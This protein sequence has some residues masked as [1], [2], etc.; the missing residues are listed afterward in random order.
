MNGQ[1]AKA[2]PHFGPVHEPS[3]GL[4]FGRF[5]YLAWLPIPLLAA[6]I[7]VGRAAGLSESYRSE[8]LTLVL[9]FTFY[10]LVSLGTLFLIGRSFLALGTPGLLLL[11]SGVVLW[12]LAGTVGDAVSHGDANVNVTIFNTGILLAGMCHLTGAILSLQPRRALRAPPLWLGAGCVLAVGALWLVTRAALANWLPVFF[13]PG[14]GGTL[15]RYCV[16]I[17]AITMFVLSAGLLLAGQREAR[18]PFTSWYALALLLL[19]VGLFGVMIQLSL[20]S[21]VNWLGRTAQWLGGLYLFLAAAAAL[22]GSQLP[23]LPP[24]RASRPALYR[25]AMAVVIVLAAA[26]V[27]L[28]F[29]SALGT[30]APYVVFFS[31]VMFAA[32]YG[33]W[34]AGL[35]ATVLSAILT[36]YFW[37]EPVGRLGV[38]QPADW[39]SLA[40]FLLSG[41]MIAWIAEALR[42]A[43]ARASAAETQA[44]LAAEREAAAEV[45]RKSEE[46]L[47]FALETIHTGAWD[48]DL[49]DH[50]AFRSFEHDRIFGY[51]QPLPEWTYEIFLEHVSPEDRPTVDGKFRWAMEN[52]SD[53]NFE[54]R[55]RRADGQVRWIMAAGRHTQDAAGNPRRMAGIVQD[56]TERKRIEE[57]LRKAHDELELRVQERTEE[58]QRTNKA[59]QAEIAERKRAEEETKQYASQLELRNRELQD[60][61]FVASHDL[62][63]P[64]RKIQ[65]FGDQLKRSCGSRLDAEEVDYLERM[66]NAALRMQALI[67][68]LL[69][70]SRVT[71]K[72]Q[73]FSTVDLALVAREVIGDLEASI[74][75]TGGQV[76]LEDLPTIQADPTQ[77]HQLLQNLVGNALKFHG[78]EKPLVKIYGHPGVQG[79][80]S[81]GARDGQRRIFVEDNGIGFDEK[82]L[83]RIFTPFQRLHGRGS[84]EGTGIG[85]AI[86]RKIVDRHG[87]TITAKSKPGKGST[88][89]VTLPIR[90]PERGRE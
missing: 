17:S 89:V 11:E 34:R 27:R 24:E 87:G 80:G 70:Y 51:A 31:A 78:A 55:I 57:A 88:F 79:Q 58:L 63:E 40:I 13:I 90:Q 68:A 30:R 22:R 62:Q 64:L 69:N 45:L 86:C 75:E 44:L 15:V 85:L 38:A 77:M 26:A 10:T 47:R 7:I 39:L 43:R 3:Q 41:C 53:W 82:Y 4:G 61:A 21:V 6:A 2:D 83:D 14:Q 49:V 32:I 50:S 52:Q 72:V 48:L 46:R 76:L 8:T 60:F 35:L 37:I 54:C 16:L 59:L 71:T 18:A 84:Y 19:A 81:G 42:Q 36:D 66:Q 28:T 23:L 20:G 67:Q 25:D 74:R 12:S 5:A 65:A 56:I 29:L 33:G 73:P 9:S 1:S